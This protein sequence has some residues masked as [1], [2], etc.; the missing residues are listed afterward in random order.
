MAEIVADVREVG[1]VG[2]DATGRRDSLFDGEVR[3]VGL[4]AQRVEDERSNAFQERP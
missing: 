1:A 2:A 4:V 3:R